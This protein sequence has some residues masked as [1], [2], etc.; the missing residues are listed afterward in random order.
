M[1]AVRRI[2]PSWNEHRGR[3]YPPFFYSFGLIED[4]PYELETEKKDTDFGDITDVINL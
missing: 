3:L 1:D 2:D 4:E